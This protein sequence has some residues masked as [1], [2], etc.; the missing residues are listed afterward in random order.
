MSRRLKYLSYKVLLAISL[1]W[2]CFLENGCSCVVSRW[3]KVLLTTSPNWLKAAKEVPSK[4]PDPSWENQ[5]TLHLSGVR[6]DSD[7]WQERVGI[8]LEMKSQ[9]Q[10]RQRL[11]PPPWPVMSRRS[12][13]E[14]TRVAPSPPSA[15]VLCIHSQPSV[16]KPVRHFCSKNSLAPRKT[17]LTVIFLVW[18]T[19]FPKR[20]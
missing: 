19:I 18:G 5:P 15:H 9:Q 4:S 2:G 10:G 7:R 14:E 12:R 16:C 13:P 11:T 3:W 20:G 1:C 17:L 8:N 6:G